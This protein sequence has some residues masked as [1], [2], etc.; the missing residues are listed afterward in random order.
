MLNLAEVNALSC[1]DF[2]RV[3]GPVFENSPWMAQ[4]A[5]VERPFGSGADL[6]RAL[7]D[8]VARASADEKLSLIRAHPDLVGNAVLTAESEG[9]Q[10]REGH[11]DHACPRHDERPAGRGDEDRA[12]LVRQAD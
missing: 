8:V 6:H 10:K 9:E 1:D 5:W 7:C 4:R 3:V 2:V 12:L 11:G